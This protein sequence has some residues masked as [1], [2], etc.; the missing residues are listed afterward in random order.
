MTITSASKPL[1]IV[2]C[3]VTQEGLPIIKL[4]NHLSFTFHL[5][6]RCWIKVDGE[7]AWEK[8]S[9]FYQL[10]SIDAITP[11]SLLD[12]NGNPMTN[13]IGPSEHASTIDQLLNRT[14][15]DVLKQITMADLEEKLSVAYAMGN[16]TNYKRCLLTYARRLGDAGREGDDGAAAKVIELLAFLGGPLGELPGLPF[17]DP[18][19]TGHNQN[20]NESV[21]GM[22]KRDLLKEILPILATNRHLQRIVLS[23]SELLNKSAF[24]TS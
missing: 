21:L 15:L 10:S 5:G 17:D 13:P 7:T 22:R 4:D 8:L 20:R 16:A 11:E 1:D 6:L 19:Q 12:S 23:Y 2:S 18:M 3:R 24:D 14:K 9:D